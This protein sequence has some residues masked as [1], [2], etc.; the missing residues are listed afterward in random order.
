MIYSVRGSI[1]WSLKNTEKS[2]VYA[3]A[4]MIEQGVT[5]YCDDYECTNNQELTYGE[6]HMYFEGINNDNYELD[7][8][9]IIATYQNGKVH[10]FMERSGTGEREFTRG[11]VPSETTRDKSV[12]KDTN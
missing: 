7:N 10:V 4:L 12:F 11:M 5:I 3:D 1:T 2:A 6:V 8:S 9:T